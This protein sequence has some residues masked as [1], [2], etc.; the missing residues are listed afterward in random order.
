MPELI[1][2]DQ[3]EH[4]AKLCCLR[5][6]S[7]EKI[8]HQQTLNQILEYMQQIREIDTKSVTPTSHILPL[9]NV[10]RQD[11]TIPSLP[12]EEALSNA[13]DQAEGYFKVS[14]IL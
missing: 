7:Q 4:M 3:V 12:R 5:L 8:D 11:K 13:P 14:R 2:L 6:S 1:S 10:L 9:I